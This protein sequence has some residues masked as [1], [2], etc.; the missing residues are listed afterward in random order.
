MVY[1]WFLPAPEN[2]VCLFQN[3]NKNFFFKQKMLKCENRNTENKIKFNQ[4][5]I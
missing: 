2:K 5:Y 4:T 3:V 1:S